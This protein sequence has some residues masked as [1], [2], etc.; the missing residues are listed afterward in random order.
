MRLVDVY[1]IPDA[2]TVLYE[3]LGKR[4][5]EQAISHQAMP[6]PEQHANF[7]RSKPYRAWYLLEEGGAYIGAAYLTEMNEI[8]VFVLPEAMVHE[9]A[10][11][12]LMV[13]SH[14][15]LPAIRSRRV[16][17]FSMNVNP[18]NKTLIDAVT[19]AGGRHVQNTY[20]L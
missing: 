5:P 10:A 17:A 8:G 13:S 19:A 16:A 12:R 20:L 4:R 14:E 1:E 6:T 2:V 11:I 15:P 3:F 9:T 18:A 7:V